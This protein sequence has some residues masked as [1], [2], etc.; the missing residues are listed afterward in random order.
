M[1][2]LSRHIERI[3]DEATNVAEEVVYLV[4]GEVIRHQGHS[5][6]DPSVGPL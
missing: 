2:L 1:I 4:E 3:A 5:D 6:S